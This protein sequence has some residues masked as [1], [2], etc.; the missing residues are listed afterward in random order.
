MLGLD[1][2]YPEL[3]KLWP[4]LHCHGWNASLVSHGGQE[5]VTWQAWVV[6]PIFKKGSGGCAPAT[7]GSHYS[8]A[9]LLEWRLWPILDPQIQEE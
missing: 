8:Y 7:G 5:I 3:L 1:E 9:R 6:V 4:S 2:M